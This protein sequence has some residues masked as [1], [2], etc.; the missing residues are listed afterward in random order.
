MSLP[1]QGAT[2][3]PAPKNPAVRLVELKIN[4]PR[5]VIFLGPATGMMTHYV[6]GQSE[7]CLGEEKC[8]KA[9]HRITPAWKGY[10]PVLEYQPDTH[11][12]HAMVLEITAGLWVESLD[13]VTLRGQQWSIVRKKEG[14]NRKPVYGEYC[15]TMSADQLPQAHGVKGVLKNI[16]GDLDFV[17]G[18]PCPIIG[19]ERIAP[20][21]GPSKARPATIPAP[22]P[23]KM[24][25]TFARAFE[26]R[27]NGIGK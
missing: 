18:V 19:K 10:A 24:A 17:L 4:I 16:Y 5:T 8:D 22:T 1:P 21:Q 3:A 9:L 14:R 6:A 25:T 26:E 13:G 15:D 11:L 7:H 20:F 12:W 2:G 27:R 23:V